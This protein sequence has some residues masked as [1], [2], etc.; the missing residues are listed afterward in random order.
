MAVNAILVTVSKLI[1][2]DMLAC[3]WERE[4]MTRPSM[5]MKWGKSATGIRIEAGLWECEARNNPCNRRF[6]CFDTRINIEYGRK[7]GTH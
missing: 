7:E 4:F 1:F 2:H 3:R 6:G 5:R